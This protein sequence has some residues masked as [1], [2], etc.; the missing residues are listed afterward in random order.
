MHGRETG[1]R[2]MESCGLNSGLATTAR[3]SLPF[4][5][6]CRYGASQCLPDAG[7][8]GQQPSR[9]E[10]QQAAQY[11]DIWVACAAGG[12]LLGIV[13]AAKGSTAAWRSGEKVCASPCMVKGRSD[14][15]IQACRRQVPFLAGAAGLE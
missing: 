12:V 14:I 4:P 7:T 11:L 5:N 9:A 13:A 3:I 2:G 15:D 10:R 8:C 6:T 1:C